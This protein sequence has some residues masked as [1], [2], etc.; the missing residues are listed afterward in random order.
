MSRKSESKY[1]KHI[2]LDDT[3]YNIFDIREAAADCDF[4]L[5]KLPYS[6]R[7]LFENVVRNGH[8]GVETMNVFKEWLKNK[9]SKDEI[10][11]MPARVLMQDFT[12][13][14][15]IV[16]LAS[17]RDAMKVLGDSP[18]KI[19]PMIPVDLVIDHSVQV[20]SYGMKSSFAENVQKEVERNKERYQF[21]KWGQNS[22]RNFRVV[23]PGT[24]IC[25]QVNL[26]YLAKCVWSKTVA[27]EPILKVSVK[28]K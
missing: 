13:V 15:A 6:L 9:T 22:F 1:A 23:P 20:D 4:E 8:G 14:P 16:D 27:G 11:Y 2:D 18:R 17:L 24:G 28:R 10:N 19:N 26:E 5:E 25:H 21:L 3:S 12:G 7:V